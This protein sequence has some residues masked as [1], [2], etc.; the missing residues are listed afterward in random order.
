MGDA[1]AAGEDDA[2]AG[3]GEG[4][5]AAL[6][7][8]FAERLQPDKTRAETVRKKTTSVWDWRFFTNKVSTNSGCEP[9]EFRAGYDFRLWFVQKLVKPPS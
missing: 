8:G 6:A 7:G 5:A 3:V 4:L 1:A 9:N 2:I